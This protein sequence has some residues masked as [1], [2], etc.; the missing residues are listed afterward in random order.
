MLTEGEGSE[1][2]RFMPAQKIRAMPRNCEA[3]LSARFKSVVGRTLRRIVADYRLNWIYAP[4]LAV[5]VQLPAG[6]SF[7]ALREHQ[8]N[9]IARS[10]YP[11]VRQALSYQLHDADGYIL[12]RD[13]EPVCVAHFAGTAAYEHS[14]TWPLRP[15]G[16]ALVDIVTAT[17]ARGF[18]YAPLLIAAA[19]RD[20]VPRASEVFA[21]IWWT[22]RASRKA[23]HKAGWRPIG[24]SVEVDLR[25]RCLALRLRLPHLRGEDGL[26]EMKCRQ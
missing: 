2:W 5:P 21:F 1:K 15:D 26:S 22:H 11:E 8:F 7:A 19:S 10:P 23:F 3:G 13:G 16:Q 9:L 25:N 20:I 12:L 17:S 6:L 4:T 14:S 24:F 18:G